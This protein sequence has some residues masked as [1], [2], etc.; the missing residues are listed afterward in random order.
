MKTERV[1][2]REMHAAI[3]AE[4]F[5]ELENVAA[6]VLETDGTFSVIRREEKQPD[7]LKYVSG[8]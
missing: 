4:G 7:T 3:R 5:S 2:E 8:P 1:T 6:V